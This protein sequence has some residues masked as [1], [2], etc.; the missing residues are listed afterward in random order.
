MAYPKPLPGFRRARV[1]FTGRLRA[2]KVRK[3]GPGCCMH[4]M[5]YYLAGNRREALTTQGCAQ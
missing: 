4:T 1:L 2:G 5:E 3:A